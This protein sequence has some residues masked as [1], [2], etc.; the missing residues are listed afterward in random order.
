MVLK[1]I[2]M[3]WFHCAI[4]VKVVLWTTTL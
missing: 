1:L 2:P 4:I 3:I